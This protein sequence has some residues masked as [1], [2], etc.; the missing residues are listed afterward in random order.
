[1][2][3]TTRALVFA[4]MFVLAGTAAQAGNV[5]PIVV[6]LFTSQGCNSCPPADL[7][8]GK[9]TQRSD[10]LALT[11]PVTYWDMLGWKDSLANEAN[12]RRQKAY[13]ATMGHGGVYTPQIIVDGVQDLVG[14][15]I[16]SVEAAIEARSEAIEAGMAIAEVHNAEGTF[17]ASRIAS[18]YE[19]TAAP[20]PRQGDPLVPVALNENGQEL[21]ITIGAI[22]GQHNATVW[23][24]HLRSAVTVAIKAGENEGRSVT[25]H[26]VVGDIRAVGI[27]KGNSL[28]L[29]L[30]RSAMAGLPHDAVAVL[31]QHGGYGHVIGASYL[32]HPDFYPSH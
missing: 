12:T 6:E 21:H 10:V 1:M 8:L 13:A 4:G 2:S 28:S 5:R 7:F 17:A 9:L 31:V 19:P 24:L 15:R 26:N 18:G 11:L 25:Y 27:W 32:S 16:A 3:G 22:G 23:L 30:P 20:A 14:S 29:T